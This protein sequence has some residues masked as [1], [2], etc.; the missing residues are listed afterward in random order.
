M[1]QEIV[2]TGQLLERLAFGKKRRSTERF[3][4]TEHF[5]LTYETEIPG[6]L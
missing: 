4:I 2:D 5:L 6:L 3:R 1:W